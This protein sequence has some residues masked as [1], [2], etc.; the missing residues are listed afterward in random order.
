MKMLGKLIAPLMLLFVAPACAQPAPTPT[1]TPVKA[2]GKTVVR[3]ADPALWVIR[4]KDTTI[5]LF[6]TIHVLKPGLSWFDG[7]VKKAFDASG[8]V[9]LEL[10][11]PDAAAMQA[12]VTSKGMAR[13]GIAL[14]QRLP[15]AKRPALGKALTDL[16]LPA[17][18]FDTMEPWYAATNLSLLPLMKKGY[19]VTNGPEQ[20]ISKAAAAQGKPVIGLETAEEQLNFF[21]SLSM[22]AQVAFLSNTIDE[23]PKLDATMTS[24]VDSWARGDPDALGKTLNEDLNA[25]PEVKKVLLVDRNK[26][27]A[28]WINQRMK[29]PGVVFIAVGAG[30][31]AGNDSVQEQLKGYRLNA[32]RV[33]Y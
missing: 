18:A 20:S 29:Q 6:G 21:D 12:L 2:A 32:K 28:Y 31:L 13:D 23:L 7:A 10:V 4:D 15:E 8:Q 30:H 3:K 17:T 25:S 16:G 22:P 19:D 14:T 1:P 24:M 26:R 9:V 27:W 11:M 33:K 5:Y